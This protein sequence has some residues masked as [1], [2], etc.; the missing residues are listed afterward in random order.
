MNLLQNLFVVIGSRWILSAVFIY[1][2][3]VKL[4]SPQNFS[5]SIAAF[6]ILPN[7]LVNLVALGLPPFEIVAGLA[8]ITGVQR[9]PAIFGLTLL[10]VAFMIALGVAIAR[11]IP[12]DCGCFG[13]G[14]PSVF[15]PWIDFGRDMVILATAIVIYLREVPPTPKA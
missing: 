2:G 8:I 1:A 6:A 4:D 3:V 11:G 9:R 5:D 13:S 10:T 15:G 12:V 7:T 14:K